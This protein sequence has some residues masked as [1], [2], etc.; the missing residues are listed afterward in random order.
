MVSSALA[1]IRVYLDIFL[2]AR[3]NCLEPTFQQLRLDHFPKKE[4][5]RSVQRP[6][7]PVNLI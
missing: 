1:S 5:L 6:L 4:Y 3:E 7:V 2:T